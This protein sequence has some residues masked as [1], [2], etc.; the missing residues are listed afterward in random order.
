MALIKKIHNAALMRAAYLETRDQ[1][2]S[3]PLDVALDLNIDRTAA[4]QIAR[5][6]VYG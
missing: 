2:R 4:K 6:A 1:L 3:L 5:R